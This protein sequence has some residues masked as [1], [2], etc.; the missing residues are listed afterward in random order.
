[1]KNLPLNYKIKWQLLNERGYKQFLNGTIS[2]DKFE[3][4]ISKEWASIARADTKKSHYGQHTGTTY[5]EV[6]TA[7][8][9]IKT[10]QYNK[11][12][13]TKEYKKIKEPISQPKQVELASGF[14]KVV[15]AINNQNTHISKVVSTTNNTS[16]TKVETKQPS[17]NIVFNTTLKSKE[18]GV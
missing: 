15:Q 16:T 7:L 3:N 17:E 11:S 2:A 10:A 4:N 8:K 18:V 12:N 9:I 13:I 1:M 5:S 14:D 6:Q